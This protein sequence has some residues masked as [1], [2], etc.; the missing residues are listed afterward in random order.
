MDLATLAWDAEALGLAEVDEARLPRILPTTAT[1]GLATTPAARVGLPAGTPVV[2]GAGDGPLANVGS[3][4]MSSGVV[5]VSLGTSGAVRVV[6]DRPPDRLDDALFCYALSDTTWVIGGAVSN[7]GIVVRWAGSSLAPDVG[8]DSSDP[9]DESLL[10]LAAQVPA[11]RD[12]LVMLPYLPSERAPLWDAELHGAYL[13]L[14]RGHTRAHL[15]RAA[16]E[17]VCLNLSL[18]VDHLHAT[19]PVTAARMTGG[20][21]RSMLWREVLAASLDRPLTVVGDAEG[22]ALGA[23][24]LGLLAR[25]SGLSGSSLAG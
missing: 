14:R 16:V 5:A 24:E 3:G 11:G 7:G 21:F 8:G 13:G 12:G 15:I 22:S 10:D 4:A 20:D 25:V 19:R 6:V 18:I 23:A 17:G 1:I 9:A 2:V